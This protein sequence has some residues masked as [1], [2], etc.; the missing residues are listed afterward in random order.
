MKQTIKLRESELKRMI[1]ESVKSVLNEEHGG[2]Y[3]QEVLKAIED[4]INST[5]DTEIARMAI[6]DRENMMRQTLARF[7]KDTFS[8]ACALQRKTDALDSKIIT[9]T[10]S[11]AVTR[12]APSPNRCILS[13]L[14]HPCTRRCLRTD[15][16]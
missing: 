5:V 12:F 4:A 7:V 13:T 14:P 3:I 1:A 6:G 9:T 2:T 8:D 16:S 10:A 11:A 15:G